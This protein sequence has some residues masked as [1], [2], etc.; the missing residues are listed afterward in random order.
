MVCNGAPTAPVTFTGT[1]AGTTFSW[2]NNTPS[3]GLAA[4]GTGDIASF[5]AINTGTAP[6]VATVTVTPTFTSGG[7]GGPVTQTFNYTGGLQ[8]FT[9]PAG[10]TSISIGAFGAQGT[11]GTPNGAQAGGSGGMGAEVS[12]TLAVTPGQVLNIYV[13]G[14]D[15][16]NGGGAAG[17]P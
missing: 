14:Q 8:T 17:A 9:V 15:G 5:N 11:S 13:G 10:V 12:G 6:V 2:I 3:I 1:V 7:G 4:T 16:F